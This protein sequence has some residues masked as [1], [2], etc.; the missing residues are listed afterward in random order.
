MLSTQVSDTGPKSS[1]LLSCGFVTAFHVC[2]GLP[3]NVITL[4]GEEGDSRCAG[5]MLV[6][7][8]FYGFMIYYS[9][10]WF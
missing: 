9:S 7:P 1:A 2:F 10:S 3:N 8:H 6:R 5:P 4:L